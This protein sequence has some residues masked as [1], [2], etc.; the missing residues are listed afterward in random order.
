M[1][2]SYL[3][4]TYGGT[5]LILLGNGRESAVEHPMDPWQHTLPELWFCV[6]P[7]IQH[8]VYFHMCDNTP[9]VTR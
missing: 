1:V 7:H 4:P 8:R 6:T 3:R 5:S 2:A 9:L